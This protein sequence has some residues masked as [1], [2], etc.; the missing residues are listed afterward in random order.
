MENL[1][2]TCS[3][4]ANIPALT[5]CSSIFWATFC[6]LPPPVH[7]LSTILFT[8]SSFLA[9]S[10]K[11]S[12]KLV[13]AG[14]KADASRLSH[15]RPWLEWNASSSSILPSCSQPA[16]SASTPL[17]VSSQCQ[18]Q[19]PSLHS[20]LVG[21]G[22]SATY[23]SQM[24]QPRDPGRTACWRTPLPGQSPRT[25]KQGR[26]GANKGLKGSVANRVEG[27][28]TGDTASSA[29]LRFAAITSCLSGC[30]LPNSNFGTSPGGWHHV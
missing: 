6:L 27:S 3:P 29:L 12:S 2:R 20:A 1:A 9:P 16:S 18:P 10:T 8:R 26:N 28:G 14:P 22:L 23:S 19:L 13:P 11:N 15:L 7:L 5:D 17:P 4:I 25:M 21:G 30:L 24:P